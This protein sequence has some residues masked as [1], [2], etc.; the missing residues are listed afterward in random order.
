MSRGAPASSPPWEGRSPTE[1]HRRAYADAEPR[2][3]WLG[4]PDAGAAPEPLAGDAECDLCIVGG[5][6]SGL[7]A[8][9]EA[10]EADPGRDVMLVE[11]ERVG[12]AA[13]GRNG[14]FFMSSLMHGVSN[15]YA[16]FP[17]EMPALERLGMENFNATVE[18]VCH[19]EI[20]CDL[21][22]TGVLTVALEPHQLDWLREEAELLRRGGHEVEFLDETKARAEIA[23]PTYLGAAWQRSGAAFL[24]PGK[25]CRGLERAARRLGVRVHEHTPIHALE[26]ATQGVELRTPNGTVRAAHALLATSAFPGLV[27]AVRRRVVPVYDYVLVSEPLAPE[28]HRSIGWERRQGVG[29]SA[30]QFHY[31]R[32]TAD[33]R[34]LW[35]GYDAI[36]NF[37]SGLRPVLEQREESFAT[38]SQHFFAPEQHRSIGWERRQGVGDSANQFH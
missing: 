7:W 1:A 20:D 17:D 18:A 5:G 31:Y 4:A 24:D 11:G 12:H 32:L 6:L 9:L 26:R 34:I 3:F 36:Y 2:P 29:D 33:D 28:Q 30:N 10:I 21:E 23:S 22:L 27:P 37:R 38:F 13:S 15:G 14:G 19:H 16:R 35:G 8:A 25:L